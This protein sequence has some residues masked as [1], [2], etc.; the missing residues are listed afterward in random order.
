MNSAISNDSIL[1]EEN[2]EQRCILKI[3]RI[4]NDFLYNCILNSY[5]IFEIDVDT[6]RIRRMPI[7]NLSSSREQNFYNTVAYVNCKKMC[8]FES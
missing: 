2:Q 6:R 5:F 3:R 7:F 4:V 8:Y 1:N